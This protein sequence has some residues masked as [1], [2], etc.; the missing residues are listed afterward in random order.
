MN[1]QNLLDQFMG[2]APSTNQQPQN[3]QQAGQ[4]GNDF[5]AQAQAALGSMSQRATQGGWTDGKGGGFAGGAVVGGLL[6]A[7]MGNK[8]MRKKAKKMGGGIVG[9]G[10]SAAL[11]ALALKAYQNYQANQSAPQQAAPPPPPQPAAIPAPQQAPFEVALLKSM[12]SAAYADGHV[13]NAER[14]AIYGAVDRLSFD[15][16]G[17]ALVFD[18]LRNPAPIA[19]I[20]GYA[21]SPE[22]ASALY[23]ASLMAIDPDEPVEQRYL[24]DLA[25]ALNLP[26]GLK[27]Q[28]EMEALGEALP[29]AAAPGRLGAGSEIF[30][31]KL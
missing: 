15:A 9:Y 8:K 27:A 6:G 28:I 22:Q 12:I 17:K 5:M 18:L 16:E 11:G 24:A 29:Q 14:E 21:Q 26:A 3:Q 31:G 2:N 4:T 25:G 20:A 10:G 19:E 30:S 7:V 13:D 1:L 23:V